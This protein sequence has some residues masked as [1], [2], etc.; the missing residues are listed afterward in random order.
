M[1]MSIG[2]SLTLA[3]LASQTLLAIGRIGVYKAVFLA[4]CVAH[5][6]MDPKDHPPKK[7]LELRSIAPLAK[8]LEEKGFVRH[9]LDRTFAFGSLYTAIYHE[10]A[11]NL[12]RQPW[13]LLS[14]VSHSRNERDYQMAVERYGNLHSITQEEYDAAIEEISD[15]SS[16]HI[17]AII[18]L[19]YGLRDGKRHTPKE[20]SEGISRHPGER[21]FTETFLSTL[22]NI[23]EEISQN[24]GETR[25][26]EM[27]LN[28]LSGEAVLSNLRSK[29]VLRRLAGEDPMIDS[30]HAGCVRLASSVPLRN[31]LIKTSTRD[32][33][34]K[35][36]FTTVGDVRGKTED[37]LRRMVPGILIKEAREIVRFLKDFE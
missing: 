34:L 17:A 18:R 31:L 21:R 5:G 1:T 32:R 33:L 25:F 12:P 26:T 19:Q 29:S 14:S 7:L 16:K 2:N 22:G 9:E 8:V 11:P 20:I 3:P 4:L 36:G 10:I 37:E 30:S 35:A 28:T 6:N 24:L 15:A 23:S 13:D 27:F